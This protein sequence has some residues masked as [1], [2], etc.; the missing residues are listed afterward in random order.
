M[1]NVMPG[2]RA[3]VI[4]DDEAQSILPLLNLNTQQGG[5]P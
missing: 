4:V 5:Q 1:Q 2:I 3:K